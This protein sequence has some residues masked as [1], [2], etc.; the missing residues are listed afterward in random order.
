MADFNENRPQDKLP[1]ESITPTFELFFSTQALL[2]NMRH[3]LT[4]K[5]GSKPDQA[6]QAVPRPVRPCPPTLSRI[7]ES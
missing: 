1:L 5:N 3:M 4:L 6:R 2:K 7:R